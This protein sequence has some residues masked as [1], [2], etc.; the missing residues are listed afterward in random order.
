MWY[1]APLYHPWNNPVFTHLSGS[2]QP[3]G[4]KKASR[5]SARCSTIFK[6]EL[7]LRTDL[8]MLLSLTR[9]SPHVRCCMLSC[10]SCLR[11]KT[12]PPPN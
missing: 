6:H 4:E 9:N 11:R 3:V 2:S 1:M 7:Q 8:P 5:V 12:T 10:V